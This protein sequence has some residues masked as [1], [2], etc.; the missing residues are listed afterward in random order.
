MIPESEM[1]Q[2]INLKELENG[3][4]DEHN[5][6]PQIYRRQNTNQSKNQ[7]DK[8]ECLEDAQVISPGR[9]HRRSVKKLTHFPLDESRVNQIDDL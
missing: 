3:I 7:N 4:I 8:E 9:N 2:N 5:L 6:K 1:I